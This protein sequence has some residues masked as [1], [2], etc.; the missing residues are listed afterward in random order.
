MS[1]MNVVKEK[2]R[3]MRETGALHVVIG[4]FSTKFVAFFGSIVIVRCLSKA[5]FGMLSYVENIYSYAFVFAGLGLMNGLL[6][7]LVLAEEPG[8][9][10]SIFK[11]IVSRSMIVDIIIGVLLCIGM[12]IFPIQEKY[13]DAKYLIFIIALLLPFQDLLTEVLYALRAFFRN[14]LYAYLAF[15]TSALLIGGRLAG[16]L[17][18]GVVGVL[19]S[20]VILNAIFSLCILCLVTRILFEKRAA[21]PLPRKQQKTITVYSVQYMITNGFWALFM[22]NDVFLIGNLLND[23]EGLADFKAAIMIPGNV[24]IFATA[25]GVFVA[26]YFTKNEKNLAWVRRNFAK[27]YKISAVVVGIVTLGLIATADFLIHLIYGNKYD[28]I[29][30]LMWV[31]LIAAFINNGLRFTTANL[32]AAMGKIRA[33]MIVS[34]CGMVLQ[35]ILDIIVIPIYGVMGVAVCSCI[36]YM[37]MAIALFVYFY[38]QYYKKNK[39]EIASAGKSEGDA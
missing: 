14:K 31:L 7:Y 18:G 39:G 3:K 9:K 10:K 33:N 11:F 34:G 13:A 24:S 29:V 28:N 32:L 20:R 19:W 2:T 17:L 26:P 30:P 23:P 27:V 21:Q 38:K 22:L 12:Q 6:R 4:T 8:E 25:I 15:G 1:V 37:L 16:A 35:V 36:E 5:D